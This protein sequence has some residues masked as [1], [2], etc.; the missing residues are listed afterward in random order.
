MPHHD[1]DMALRRMLVSDEIESE[2]VRV[3]GF[4]R[5]RQRELEQ[6]IEETM[7]GRFDLAPAPQIVRDRQVGDGAIVTAR[8]TEGI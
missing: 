6:G 1:W 8:C 2:P 5:E 4:C 7:F 3:F